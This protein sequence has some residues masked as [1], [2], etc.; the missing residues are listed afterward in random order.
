MLNKTRVFL[1]VHVIILALL[2]S[3]K[4]LGVAT[5]LVLVAAIAL[6]SM[7]SIYMAVFT[8]E[9]TV[10][11]CRGVKEMEEE[12]AAIKETASETV[13]FQRALLY[14]GHQIKN[15][16]VSLDILKKR[17]DFKF[18]GNVHQRRTQHPIIS[19]S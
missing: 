15:I 4:F 12:M 1:F 6:I 11:A 9:I 10:K 2:F 5:D 14:T 3:M 18:N 13:K 19:Q 16:Q 17:A 8:K 7:E